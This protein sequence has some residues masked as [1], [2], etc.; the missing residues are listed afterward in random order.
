MKRF[1]MNLDKI[2][3][4]KFSQQMKKINNNFRMINDKYLKII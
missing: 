2:K 4:I 3:L 1:L